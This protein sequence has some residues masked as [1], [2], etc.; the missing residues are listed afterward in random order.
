MMQDKSKMKKTLGQ[1]IKILVPLVCITILSFQISKSEA[2]DSLSMLLNGPRDFIRFELLI[3]AI[4]LMP[5]NWLIESYK[6]YLIINKAE[7]ISFKTSVKATLSGLSVSI[8]SIIRIGEYLGRIAYL[9]KK[10]LGVLLTIVASMTQLIATLFYGIISLFIIDQDLINSEQSKWIILLTLTLASSIV[11]GLKFFPLWIKNLIKWERIRKI[12]VQMSRIT[13]M[14]LLLKIQGLSLVR[15]MVFA[16][17]Y[18]MMFY[19]FNFEVNV[20]QLFSIIALMY[21]AT[22]AVPVN[23]IIDLGASK[24][25]IIKTL[26]AATIGVSIIQESWII[27][28]GFMIW[29]INIVVP[30][31]I[32]VFIISFRKKSLID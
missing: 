22:T 21:L 27:L 19:A 16:S 25:I 23:Q 2:I 10:R 20:I 12:L 17:Q 6:W 28:I 8:I 18:M 1:V 5:L 30:S 24:T 26:L 15:Y 11:V 3:F 13:T 29:V 7:S 4:L 14:P 32:G 31:L 9:K